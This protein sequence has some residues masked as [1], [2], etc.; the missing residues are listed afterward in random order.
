MIVKI[1]Q[2]FLKDVR[3]LNNSAINLKIAIAIESA[4]MAD[5]I[6]EIKNLKKLKGTPN[7]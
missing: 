4:Q 3:K 6:H 7:S 5:S 2:A 1:D